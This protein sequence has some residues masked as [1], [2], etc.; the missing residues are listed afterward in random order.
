M[1]GIVW[2]TKTLTDFADSHTISHQT[3]SQMVAFSTVETVGDTLS[4][5]LEGHLVVPKI[6]FQ[7]LISTF[8]P[9][10]EK[11]L[12][13]MVDELSPLQASVESQQFTQ[14]SFNAQPFGS[15]F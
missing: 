1:T 10:N 14:E 8:I 2:A 13:T 12:L 6:S 15:R 7:K 5:F 9:F 3:T 11:L 4:S